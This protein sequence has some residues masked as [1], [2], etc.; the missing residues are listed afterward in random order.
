MISGDWRLLGACVQM[1]ADRDW[2]FGPKYDSARYRGSVNGVDV[3]TDPRDHVVSGE[4]EV[5][6]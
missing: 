1:R 3:D 6:R 4:I 2:D 5:R